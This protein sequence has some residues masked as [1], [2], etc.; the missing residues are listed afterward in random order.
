M[1]FA[2]FA[3]DFKVVYQKHIP[4]IQDEN[5]NSDSNLVNIAFA[6][7]KDLDFIQERTKPAI[8][9]Y[10]HFNRTKD[11]ERYFCNLLKDLG[12]IQE[13]TKPAI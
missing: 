12:L 3:S 6:L 10:P 8:K 4:D 9:R 11:S 2:S 7:Q 5:S 13:R 1:C